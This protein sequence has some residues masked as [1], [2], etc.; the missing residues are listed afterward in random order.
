M[1]FDTVKSLV[2]L[3][4]AG[5]VGWKIYQANKVAVEAVD[6]VADVA[7]DV[8]QAR[9]DLGASIGGGLYQLFN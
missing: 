6:A 2:L 7:G 1:K 5:F 9:K 4:G 3:A 8:N